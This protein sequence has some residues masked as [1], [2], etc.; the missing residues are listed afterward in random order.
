M[1][2]GGRRQTASLPY[3]SGVISGLVWYNYGVNFSGRQQ[4]KFSPSKARVWSKVE[5]NADVNWWWLRSTRGSPAPRAPLNA[6]INTEVRNQSAPVKAR[7]HTGLSGSATSQ[8][9]RS[10]RPVHK[11]NVYIL[12]LRSPYCAD[13][14]YTDEKRWA[15]VRR[16][17][18]ILV[19]Y[20]RKR[21]QRGHAC[22]STSVHRLSS[23]R[24]ADEDRIRNQSHCRNSQCW[25]TDFLW[26]IWSPLCEWLTFTSS[27]RRRHW[28]GFPCCSVSFFS[29]L[30]TY[31]NSIQ[32]LI[33]EDFCVWLLFYL[34]SHYSLRGNFHRTANN[35]ILKDLQRL[36]GMSKSH[37]RIFLCDLKA[38]KRLMCCSF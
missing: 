26:L 18:V 34:H 23:R 32:A 5:H 6:R 27:R 30:C 3:V 28:T 10:L 22:V 15:H 4:S 17:P 14:L 1:V 36:A 29:E 33:I 20:S 9:C 8:E 11:V 19:I 25:D 12:L 2:C 31:S 7:H 38:F 37:H 16:D 21:S 35:N 24:H 13:S